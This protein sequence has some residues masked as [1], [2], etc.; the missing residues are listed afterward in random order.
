MA[1]QNKTT[2]QSS[3]SANAENKLTTGVTYTIGITGFTYIKDWALIRGIEE[4]TGEKVGV[5]IG[6][7]MSFGM[8]EMFQLKQSEGIKATYKKDKVVN[9]KTYRQFQLE[10]ILF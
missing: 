5:I 2:N 8:T 3:G 9:G 4:T 6:D 7:K 10:E 1:A